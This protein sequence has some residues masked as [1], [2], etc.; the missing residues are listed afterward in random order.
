MFRKLWKTIKIFVILIVILI[1]LP[2]S[3]L[4]KQLSG[5]KSQDIDEYIKLNESE[6]R[7]SEYK[8][9]IE[10]LKLKIVQLDVINNSRKKFRAQPVKL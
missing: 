2:H 6:T 3:I 1:C 4:P 7:L 5:S 8:D 10:A 9:D